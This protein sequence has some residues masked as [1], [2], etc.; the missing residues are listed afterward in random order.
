MQTDLTRDLMAMGLKS[1]TWQVRLHE[2]HE[3]AEFDLANISADTRYP[4]RLQCEQKLMC[5]IALEK[6]QAESLITCIWRSAIHGNDRYPQEV[7]HRADGS[8]GKI[9]I[10][11]NTPGH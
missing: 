2:T 5:A 10:T 4:F 6:V 1:P 3:K 7:R 11:A 9:G 8:A